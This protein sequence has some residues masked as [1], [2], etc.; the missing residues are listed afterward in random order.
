MECFLWPVVVSGN[1]IT[2]VFLKG[3]LTL[4]NVYEKVKFFKIIE[5]R[6]TTGSTDNPFGLKRFFSCINIP[7]KFLAWT[8]LWTTFCIRLVWQKWWRLVS[9]WTEVIPYINNV[10]IW[11]PIITVSNATQRPLWEKNVQGDVFNESPGRRFRNLQISSLWH[12]PGMLHTRLK[13]ASEMHPCQLV[14]I[15][16]VFFI[17]IHEVLE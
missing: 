3:F 17:P 12:V 4:S 8:K 1:G 14:K 2:V 5:S 9:R 11:K 7:V 15:F 16:I 6:K 10:L 13:D